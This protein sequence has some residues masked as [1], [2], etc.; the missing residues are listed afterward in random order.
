MARNIGCI[1]AFILV[2]G[3]PY[4]LGKKKAAREREE[5][6]NGLNRKQQNETDKWRQ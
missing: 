3:I 4:Y 2:Y 1:I 5:M 6:Y